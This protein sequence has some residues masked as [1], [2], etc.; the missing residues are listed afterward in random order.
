MERVLRAREIALEEGLKYVYTGNIPD[1]PGDSTYSPRTGQVVIERTG[2][3]VV[4]NT[5]TNGIAPD[6]TPI[7]GIWK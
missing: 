6:G 7:P 3:Y 4:R 2:F 5:L 1:S